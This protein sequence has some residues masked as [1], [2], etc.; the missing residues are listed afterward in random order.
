MKGAAVLEG[1]EDVQRHLEVRPRV[2]AGREAVLHA[3]GVVLVLEVPDVV[4]EQRLRDRGVGRPVAVV[5]AREDP[6]PAVERDV[7]GG[8]DQ[9]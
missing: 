5:R 7:E 9:T 2:E 8:R 4:A 1:H 3:E 6:D